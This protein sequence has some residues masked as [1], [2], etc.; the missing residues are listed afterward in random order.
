LR[1]GGGNT[2]PI[3]MCQRGEIAFSR[4]FRR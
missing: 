1:R 4:S 3:L 2:A